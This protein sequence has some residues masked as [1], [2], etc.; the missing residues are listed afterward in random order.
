MPEARAAT[1]SF[2]PPL[3]PPLSQK[4]MRSYPLTSKPVALWKWRPCHD[5]GVKRTL[6]LPACTGAPDAS[7]YEAAHDQSSQ[8]AVIASP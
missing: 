5:C 3:P 2:W 8:G 7:V 6:R 4:E 1:R